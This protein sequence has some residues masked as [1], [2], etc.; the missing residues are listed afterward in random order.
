MVGFH[1]KTLTREL[2]SLLD[3]GVCGVILFSRN[4]ESPLQVAEL[5][6]A[7]KRRAGRPIVISVDQEGGAVARL[8]EGFTRLPPMRALGAVDDPALSYAVGQ[9]LGRELRAVGIDLDYA[10]VL[11][12]DTNP[13]NPVIGAR[14][15]GA[16]P[17]LVARHGVALAKGLVS[18]RVAPC[19]KHFPGHGDTLQD[20][21]HQL[22]RLPHA[23]ERLDA[24]ELVPFR[25][26]IGAEIPALM[27]AHVLF[28]A[29]DPEWPATASERVIG[30]LL[31]GR[32]GFDGLVIT[33]DLEMRAIADH[34]PLDEVVVRGLN[35]GVD[36]FLCCHTHERVLAIVDA[37]ERALSA[38][39][40]PAHRFERA[41]ERVTAFTERWAAP[42]LERFDETELRSE[43]SLAIVERL[44]AASARAEERDPTSFSPAQ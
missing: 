5:T 34:Y 20:S 35:A 21:H 44:D 18:Q 6:A 31:R 33:D 41:F 39:R 7:I 12:V 13:Y 38:G 40:I 30:E 43:E 22:P 8:R 2:E 26:A 23:L 14:S 4:V 24:V 29:L 36:S 19:G 15:F 9:L 16:D 17:A 42:P 1:G 25:A 32:L 11:D 3:L 37:I 10:P 27:T 28:E